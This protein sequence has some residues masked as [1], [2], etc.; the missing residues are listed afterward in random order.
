MS[1]ST[2][3]NKNA[4]SKSINIDTCSSSF[5]NVTWNVIQKYFDDNPQLLVEHHTQSYN[6]FIDRGLKNI[7]LNNFMK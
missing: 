1:Q 3:Q 7:I 5:N 2:S 4:N 6:A